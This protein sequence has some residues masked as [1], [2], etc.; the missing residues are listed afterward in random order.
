[1]FKTTQELQDFI[2]WCQQAK[3][4]AV[5]VGDLEVQFSD[6]AFIDVIAPEIAKLASEE[7][8]TSKTMVDTAADEVD[9]ELLF[10]SS[11]A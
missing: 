11:K 3:I 6:L 10:W 5:K 7:R 8:D 2:L 1:V 4:K 9:E